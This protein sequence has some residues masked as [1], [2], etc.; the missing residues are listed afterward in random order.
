[1]PAKAK[2][3]EITCEANQWRWRDDGTAP[4]STEGHLMS[5]GDV[6]TFDSWTTPRTNWRAVLNAIQVIEVTGTPVLKISWYD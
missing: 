2:G 4:T 6:L 5:P 1:M 3:A